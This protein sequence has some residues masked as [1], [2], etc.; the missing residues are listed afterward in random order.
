MSSKGEVSSFFTGFFIGALIGAATALVLA[1]QSGEETRSQIRDKSIELKGKA[2]TTY[3]DVLK[4][5]EATTEELRQK[6]EEI[7]VKVDEAV[8]HGKESLARL[9]K[10]GQ[11]EAEGVAEEEAP[12]EA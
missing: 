9:G 11:E 2:E 3:G 5:V 4:R 1:P 6:T 12:A 7:S 10:R 8:A